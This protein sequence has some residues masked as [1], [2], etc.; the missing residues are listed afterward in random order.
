[1]KAFSTIAHWQMLVDEATTKLGQ[2][3]DVAGDQKQYMIDAGFVVVRDDV[4]K[5]LFLNA[6]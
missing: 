3:L 4:Y 1:M 2:M 6:F 5:V